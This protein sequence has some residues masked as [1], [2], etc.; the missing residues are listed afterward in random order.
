VFL[1]TVYSTYSGNCNGG[2]NPDTRNYNITGTHQSSGQALPDCKINWI[3]ETSSALGYDHQYD[4]SA[5]GICEIIIARFHT[6]HE[7]VFI[8]QAGGPHM[9]NHETV[10]LQTHVESTG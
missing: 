8:L 5:H 3:K 4:L 6:T 9:K 7:G 10:D 1:D 2:Y